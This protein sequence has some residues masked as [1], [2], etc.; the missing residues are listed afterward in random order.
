MIRDFLRIAVSV[1]ASNRSVTLS[2]MNAEAA[3]LGGFPYL[4]S[5][6]GVEVNLLHSR[7]GGTVV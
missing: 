2:A 3:I 1:Q 7:N 4:F 5:N 6:S